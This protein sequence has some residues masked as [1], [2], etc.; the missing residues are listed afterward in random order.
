MILS[1]RRQIILLYPYQLLGFLGGSEVKNL[2]ANAGDAGSIPESGSFPRGGQDN[3]SSILAWRIPWTEEPGRLRPMRSEKSQIWLSDSTPLPVTSGN[4]HFCHLFKMTS[5]RLLCNWQVSYT[6]IPWNLTSLNF[7]FC[8]LLYVYYIS[9][10][11]NVYNLWA[12]Y[13]YP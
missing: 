6:E 3:H 12:T 2:L 5:A 7:W 13:L 8:V 11:V 9:K 10:M 1:F 4:V